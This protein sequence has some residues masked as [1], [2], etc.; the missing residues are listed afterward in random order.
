[1]PYKDSLLTVVQCRIWRFLLDNEGSEIVRPWGGV[2][3]EMFCQ[4]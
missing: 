1:L 4:P 3:F 2:A